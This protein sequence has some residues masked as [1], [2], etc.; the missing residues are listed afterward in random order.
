MAVHPHKKRISI[1]GST[2]SVGTNTLNL[3]RD[4][5][6]LFDVVG[7]SA[8]SSIEVLKQQV[9]EFSPR[10]VSVANE[11]LASA[12]RLLLPKSSGPVV[13]AGTEGH[14]QIVELARPDVVISAMMGTHGLEATLQAVLQSVPVV[15]IANKEILVMAGSFIMEAVEQSRSSLVPVDSEHSAI[16]QAL[17]GNKLSS[18]KNII[19][20]GSGGPFRTRELS[21]FSKITKSEAL[22]HPNW[23]MGSKITIDSATMMNKGLEYIEALRLFRIHRDQLKVVIH[24]ESIVHSLVEYVD[25]SFMA[26]LG[27]SDMRI[28]ISLA[29]NYP[30]RLAVHFETP[31]DLVKIG[32]LNF[33]SPDLDKFKCLKLA[34]NFDRYGSQG[35]LVLNAANEVAVD[36]FLKDQISF[37][38]IP[39]IVE[40]SLEQFKTQSAYSLSEVI[41]LDRTVK[42]WVEGS[43]GGAKA[44]VL[45][46]SQPVNSIVDAR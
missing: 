42:R 24:P 2:G 26:Q 36:L 44:P 17:M 9:E 10:F 32:R 28:P 39:E 40:S 12:L 31:F 4:N 18:V 20:T 45:L 33:E 6:D 11:G 21:S 41:E 1:L 14:R 35:A 34:M 27:N 5:R 23:V 3:I 13:F 7:L 46:G 15:G 43:W 22:K 16:F 19:L 38:E 30:D 25:G 8:G 37:V 29:L